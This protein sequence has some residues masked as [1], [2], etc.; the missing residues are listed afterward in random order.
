MQTGSSGTLIGW[1]S[2]QTTFV[3]LW[4][5]NGGSV[6]TDSGPMDMVDNGEYWVSAVLGTCDEIVRHMASVAYREEPK[7]KKT[8]LIRRLAPQ[9]GIVFDLIDGSLHAKL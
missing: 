7:R 9:L 1:I 2:G 6:A 8:C 5:P 4:D 3:P